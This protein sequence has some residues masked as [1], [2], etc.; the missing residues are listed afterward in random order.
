MVNY[1]KSVIYK[2]VC[3]D[4]NITDCYVGSTANDLRKRK[5][6]HKKCCNKSNDKDYNN[7]KYRVIRDKGGWNNWDM[8]EVERYEAVDKQDLH[9]RERYWLEQLGATLNKQIPTGTKKEWFKTN[10]DK[11]KESRK[12]YHIDNKEKI[13]ENYENNKEL[14]K[15]K[16]KEYYKEWRDNNKQYIKE[17]NKEYREINKEKI[18]IK[19]KEY[20]ENNNEYIKQHKKDYYEN[21][22]DKFNMKVKCEFC[23]KEMNQSSLSRHNKRKHQL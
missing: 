21:N 22:K 20:I 1:A 23:D 6:E 2:I 14:N 5:N 17:K 10:E 16:Y 15:G 12:K 7:Y 3:K 18:E 11:L 13:K 9:K 4:I 8:V 19:M